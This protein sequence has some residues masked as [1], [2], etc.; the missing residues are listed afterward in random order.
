M[1]FSQCSGMLSEDELAGQHGLAMIA[2]MIYMVS[3]SSVCMFVCLFFLKS[4]AN[5]NVLIQS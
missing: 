1:C 2:Y 5:S 4:K 3:F